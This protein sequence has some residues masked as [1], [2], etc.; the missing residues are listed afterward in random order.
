MAAPDRTHSQ[1][2]DSVRTAV[3]YRE[4]GRRSAHSSHGPLRDNVPG[5]TGPRLG[6]S[7]SRQEVSQPR[8]HNPLMGLGIRLDE[9]YEPVTRVMHY[10]SDTNLAS[11][12][13]MH[14]IVLQDNDR[15]FPAF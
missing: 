1:N 14:V 15:L 11:H 2:V 3:R 9:S 7:S 13:A 6:L 4:C 8:R 10:P 5:L 12:L